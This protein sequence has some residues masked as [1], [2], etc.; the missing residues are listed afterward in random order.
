MTGVTVRLPQHHNVSMYIVG[1]ITYM[2]ISLYMN[3]NFVPHWQRLCWGLFG[4][5]E[6]H[7]TCC[8]TILVDYW[9]NPLL[10]PTV[11]VILATISSIWGIFE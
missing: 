9:Q 6:R 11:S 5:T 10:S 1:P 2:Y 7:T 4:N 8:Q 3:I